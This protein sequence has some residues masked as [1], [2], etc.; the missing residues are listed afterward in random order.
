MSENENSQEKNELLDAL[1]SVEEVNVGDVVKGEV[2][3]IDDDKQVI[4]G[5]QGTGVEGVVPL[6]EL[7]TQRVDD[8]NEAAKV[9]DVLDLVVISRIGSDKENGSYLLSHR[10]LEAR[11]VWDDVEKEY[12]AGHM[13]KAPVTQ[14]VKGGLVVD[15]GVRG[16]IP[17]SMIDDHYVEDLNAYKGQELELKIIEI[18]PSENRLI[19]SHRAVVEK[20]REA[21]REE[22]LKTLQA[23]DVVEGK[24]ARLTNFGAF[25]DLGGIDGL[26]HVSEI[27]YER[28]EKPADVLKVGQEVTVKIL[29]V[30]ADRERVSLSIKATLPE[31]WDGIEEKAPQ[32]AVLD[33]KVKRLTSFGAFVEVFPGVEGLVHISQISHQH[34]ATPNDVLK[35]GQEIKVKV[36]DVRPD[37]KR[38][39]LSIKA[40]E[41]KPQTAD[42]DNESQPERRSNNNRR[43]NNNRDNRTASERSTANAPEESTGFTLGDLIGDELKNAESN[44]DE[45]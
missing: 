24:V 28:V 37:E 7:S 9:G 11:K 38:L 4:V 45:N 33:G 27:S 39:A 15:A 3:A 6:K 41:E 25:V 14:V 36:L 31:P 12:E 5:I 42:D 40:L 34:I 29:S 19:L 20:Q 21:Q 43:R 13:I 2:L 35:V 1:N 8:V 26:V 22:A 17:A 32:G 18:E 16:F 10:R 44:N 30:D 23:G